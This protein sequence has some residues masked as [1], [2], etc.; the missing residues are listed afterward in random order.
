MNNIRLNALTVTRRSRSPG[1]DDSTIFIALPPSAWR[2]SFPDSPGCS[3]GKCNG[4]AYWD[5]LA[6]G[7]TPRKG[8]ADVTWTV[9]YPELHAGTPEAYARLAREASPAPI[10]ATLGD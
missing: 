1:L 3:C 5:T 10:P 2:V 9:H 6:V 4:V 7:A 8:Q